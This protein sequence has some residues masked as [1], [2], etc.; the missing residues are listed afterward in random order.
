MSQRKTD[1]FV[2]LVTLSLCLALSLIVAAITS[3]SV[4]ALLTGFFVL[5]LGI[6]IDLRLSSNQL[7]NEAN[8]PL[9]GEYQRFREDKCELFRTMA[10]E[11]YEEVENFFRNL[12]ENRIEESDPD[13]IMHILEFLF[14]KADIVGS[15]AATSYGELDEWLEETSWVNSIYLQ[16]QT[17]A[18]LR[19]VAVERIFIEADTASGN[20]DAVCRLHVQ[21][22]IDVKTVRSVDISP[23]LI[24]R[25]GNALVFYDHHGNPVYAAQA[26][27]HEG[28]LEKIVFFRDQ[29]HVNEINDTYMH[30]RALAASYHV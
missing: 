18:H 27:H 2:A 26:A 21:H 13:Q 28:K 12:R 17:S 16:M 24:P 10:I 22:F 20:L 25:S 30:I 3:N 6:F 23:D 19:G 4:A 14:A 8:I 5:M 15:I 29:D 11:K 9:V 1:I 7:L